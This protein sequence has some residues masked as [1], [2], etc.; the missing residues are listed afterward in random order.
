[1]HRLSDKGPLHQRAPPYAVLI[2]F[3]QI[4]HRHLGTHSAAKTCHRALTIAISPIGRRARPQVTLAQRTLPDQRRSGLG[5]TTTP[6]EKPPPATA[7]MH[8]SLKTG[9]APEE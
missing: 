9:S 4:S 2:I 1:M 8:A 6:A 7:T 5:E 3:S